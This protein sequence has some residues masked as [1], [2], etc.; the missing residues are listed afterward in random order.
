MGPLDVEA[1]LEVPSRVVGRQ[2]AAPGLVHLGE[3]EAG[4]RRRGARALERQAVLGTEGVQV[5]G[6][7]RVVIGVHDG[8]R[9]TGTRARGGGEAVGAL[10]RAWGKARRR[11][12][13]GRD[14]ARV[15]EVRQAPGSAGAR[16]PA[17]WPSGTGKWQP[18]A[19]GIVR[20]GLGA[21]QLGTRP[22]ELSRR[23]G[24]R[25]RSETGHDENAGGDRRRP[26]RQ[27]TA[28]PHNPT[29]SH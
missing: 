25:Q 16:P 4:R 23:R 20:S 22:V 28:S 18:A 9:A 8:D 15:Q 10:D 17:H 1:Y 24:D 21:P 12:G 27:S 14:A 11:G 2:G 29:A 6:S 5:G 3:L 7:A 13:V 26:P 19:L